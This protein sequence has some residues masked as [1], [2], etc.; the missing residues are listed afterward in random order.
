M[1]IEQF[2]RREFIGLLGAA[3]AGWPRAARAQAAAPLIGFLSSRSPDE[4][5]A[6]LAA[7]RQGL[8]E[9]GYVERRNVAIEY[10]WSENRYDRLPALAS[11][12][13]AR[14]VAVIA[15]V[16]GPVTALAIKATT[17]TIPFV[18]ISGVDP[19]KLGLVDS[20][21][22]PGGNAT[23]VNMLTTAVEAKRLG[24]LHELVPFAGRIAILLNP[25]SS[26]VG[27]Q[28]SDAETACRALG[29]E[30]QMIRI[31]A[32]DEIDAGFAMAL[33]AAAQAV[34]VMA[35]P[36]FSDRRERIVASAARHKL[37]SIYET[38]SYVLAGGL[39]SYGPNVADMYRQVGVYTGQIL[40]GIKPADLPV[41]QPTA[42]ELAINLKT[43][44]ALGLEVPPTL[45]AHADEVI[46]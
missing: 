2:R 25:N 5:S 14:N 38:R 32:D 28:L 19:V 45:L 44:K 12:L 21:A 22:R 41:I 13:V 40:K 6:D 26:E 4:S 27:S 36:F 20:F 8:G 30:P 43:A 42:L 15:A 46:E 3:A 35:D 10:R 17:T 33:R 39:I 31:S 34:L 7:F 18:F 24:L 29:I 9:A 16:G 1:R 11:D 37:P 23:G